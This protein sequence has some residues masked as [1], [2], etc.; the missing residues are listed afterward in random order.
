MLGI[1]GAGRVVAGLQGLMHSQTRMTHAHHTFMRVCQKCVCVGSRRRR[2]ARVECLKIPTCSV[3]H[4]CKRCYLVRVSL[5]VCACASSFMLPNE[6]RFI[7]ER[8]RERCQRATA[9]AAQQLHQQLKCVHV[10]VRVCVSVCLR[11]CVSACV[12]VGDRRI[13]GA[14]NIQLRPLPV[15][16]CV[17]VCTCAPVVACK[18]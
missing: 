17:C 6:R 15:P 10:C 4:A 14:K 1:G 3:W 16:S 8:C 18:I 2:P 13:S 9:S 7:Q 5:S 12:R 11:V